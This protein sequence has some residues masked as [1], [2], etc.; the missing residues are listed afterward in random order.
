MQRKVRAAGEHNLLKDDPSMSVQMISIILNYGF[1][2]FEGSFL[3]IM[4]ILIE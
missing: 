2:F 4:L 3:S 1:L